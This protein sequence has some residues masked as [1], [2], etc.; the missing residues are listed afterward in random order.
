MHTLKSISPAAVPAA[1]EKALRY[2]LLN[3]PLE[4][5]S[6]CL[7]IL[8]VDPA[9]Q[10]AHVTLLLARTD[11]FQEEYMEAFERAKAALASLTDQYDRAYY[12]GVIHERWAKAQ[13][14]RR[15]PSHTVTGWYLHAMHCYERAIALA[16]ADNPDAVLRW[17]TCARVLSRTS[18]KP[19]PEQ[20]VNRDIVTEYD[21]ETPSA[22]F[23]K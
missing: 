23:H 10:E 1:L 14:A 18:D 21:D 15:V 4:A 6:V 19:A 17:N 16:P 11:L 20:E 2:R 5:E 9:N 12:E 3:E 8:R 13:T 22:L 7:D